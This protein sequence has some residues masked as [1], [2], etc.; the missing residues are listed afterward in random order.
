MKAS[1]KLTRRKLLTAFAA[2]TTGVLSARSAVSL[3]G[4][5]SPASPARLDQNAELSA[6]DGHGHLHTDHPHGMPMHG[7]SMNPLIDR[8]PRR[9]P[10]IVLSSPPRTM[11]RQMGR[12]VTPGI[13]P[14]GY[15]MDGDVKVFELIAQPVEVVITEPDSVEHRHAPTIPEGHQ[16]FQPRSSQ[17]KTMLAWGYNGNC[18]GPTLEATEGDRVRIILRN[19]LPEPTSIHW[20]GFEQRHS[21]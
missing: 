9:H 15:R 3:A 5:A 6:A 2:A 19:E 21:D 20:H 13:P 12:V 17:P 8:F 1:K 14:L 18:P 10:D 11:G 16:R 4:P 7:M